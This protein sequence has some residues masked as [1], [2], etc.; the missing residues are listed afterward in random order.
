MSG[1]RLATTPGDDEEDGDTFGFDILQQVQGNLDL[2]LIRINLLKFRSELRFWSWVFKFI[3]SK[4]ELE[5][6][7]LSEI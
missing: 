7:L 4:L 1:H 6:I 3:F 2:T 5:F